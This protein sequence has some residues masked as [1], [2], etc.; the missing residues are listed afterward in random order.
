MLEVQVFQILQWQ[1]QPQSYHVVITST[2]A[3]YS[4][5]FQGF[6]SMWC[7]S[8]D[9]VSLTQL[10]T[11]IIAPCVDLAFSGQ[12]CKEATAADLKIDYIQVADR[13]DS[14]RCVKVTK[15]ATAPEVK[16]IVYR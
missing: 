15:G 5:S 10:T 2:D 4:L 7:L 14:V 8:L 16:L 11:V 3:S 13:L 9:L 12:Q 1:S 6:D